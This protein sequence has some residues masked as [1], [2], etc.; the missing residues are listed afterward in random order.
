MKAEHSP[1]DVRKAYLHTKD[2]VRVGFIL[3]EHF[4]LLAFTAAYDALVTANLVSHADD[5]K[6]RGPRYELQSYG[7]HQQQ[8]VSDLGIE[9][10]AVDQLSV[11]GSQLPDVLIVCGGFR[12][13]LSE[14]TRVSAILRRAAKQGVILGGIW[15]GAVSMAHAG[16]LQETACTL[17]PDNH[18]LMRETFPLIALTDKPFQFDNNILTCAGGA[19]ALD[20]TLQLVKHLQGDAITRA[21]REILSCDRFSETAAPGAQNGIRLA[22]CNDYP[23]ELRTMIQLMQGNIEEPL[24]IDELAALAGLSRRK[25]ERLFQQHLEVSPSRYYMQLR[26][27]YAKCLLLQSRASVTDIAVASGF[28]SSSHFSNCFKGFFG[29]A[30]SDFREQ[31]LR[32]SV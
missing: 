4:S 14:D 18:A 31:Q 28:V 32:V 21:V 5:C 17:H 8:V 10:S 25:T 29:L 2:A 11:L 27:K 26:I 7:V 30:P 20:M 22:D 13:E 1:A 6:E 19:S 3:L 9:I 15:N 12:C 16:V 23:D 24:V